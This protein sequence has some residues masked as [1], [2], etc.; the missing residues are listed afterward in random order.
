M[1][2]AKV[3]EYA[4][5]FWDDGH[6]VWDDYLHHR[7]FALTSDSEKVIRWFSQWR[8]IESITEL[9]S[10]PR[11]IAQRLLEEK[12]LV[13]RG[14]AEH[15][16]QERL[17]EQWGAWGPGARYHHFAARADASTTYMSV[18]EDE[19]RSAAKA[20]EN[21]AP[22]PAKSYPGQPLTPVS[23]DRPDTSMWPHSDV[24]DALHSR[25]SVRQY[26]PEPVSLD[27]LGTLVQLAA[28]P[29]QR[30]DHPEVGTVLLKTSPSAGARSPI[31]VYVH[32]TAVEGLEP[33]L[34]HFAP[35]RGGLERLGPPAAPQQLAAAVGGQPWLSEC[36]ALIIYTAVLERTRW[37]YETR[38]AYRDILIEVGH[39]SQTVL[40]SAAAMG[41]GA[42]TATALVD[43][44]LERILGCDG[45][46][47]PAL[48]VTALGH[49]A[50][51]DPLR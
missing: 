34:Y 26:S 1:T 4:A 31:E 43:D 16:E 35:L 50:V 22:E 49:P 5:L 28:G 10:R 20:A 11:A 47:E 12:V 15:S 21:P 2:E 18:I 46:A 51:V 48:A 24:V 7:Q 37:R 23:T 9:G 44:E 19:L 36:A 25:R 8:D 33:G 6:L 38:R 45:T 39:V 40:L 29:V 32:V 14:S 27:A 13:A 30:I 42:V 41:L 17:L 3:A